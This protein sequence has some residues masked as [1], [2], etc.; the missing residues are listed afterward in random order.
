MQEQIDAL[1]NAVLNIGIWCFILS[2]IIII[3]ALS[4]EDK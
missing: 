3:L 4:K 1:R 2:V